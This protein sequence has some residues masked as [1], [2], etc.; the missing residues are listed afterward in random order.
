MQDCRPCS[1]SPRTRALGLPCGRSAQREGYVCWGGGGGGGAR[2]REKGNGRGQGKGG[3][4]WG[5][6]GRSDKEGRGGSRELGGVGGQ[7]KGGGEGGEGG[8]GKKGKWA[9]G[10]SV[11]RADSRI[12]PIPGPKSPPGPGT[13]A[14]TG[15]RSTTGVPIPGQKTRPPYTSY[16]LVISDSLD[17]DPN[18]SG[19]R[20][21]GFP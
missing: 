8:K 16:F 15:C 21:R 9:N 20:P 7:G 14:A 12:L 13:S 2:G 18:A 6:C 17:L 5:Q 3:G 19:L 4:V 1:R 10:V 11:A